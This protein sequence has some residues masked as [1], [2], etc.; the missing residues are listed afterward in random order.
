[1]C[2]LSKFTRRKTITI[3]KVVE[4]GI[5]GKFYSYYTG[6]PIEI[7]TVKP[8]NIDENKT[9]ITIRGETSFIIPSYNSLA[10]GRIMGYKTIKTLVS[11]EISTRIVTVL[12]MLISGSIVTNSKETIYAGTEILS[13]KKIDITKYLKR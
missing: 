9:L 8:F 11:A 2:N 10:L 3:Y 13:F 5:D 6:Y 12:K 7:G 4:E 1:M